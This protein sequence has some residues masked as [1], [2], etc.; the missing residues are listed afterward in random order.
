[1]NESKETEEIKTVPTTPRSIFTGYMGSRPCPTLN[2]TQPDAP[3]TQD[4]QYL[5]LTQSPPAHL[6]NS[7]KCFCF[8]LKKKH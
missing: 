4:T 2:Q 7:T 8:D 1:M 3:E 6:I 5:C